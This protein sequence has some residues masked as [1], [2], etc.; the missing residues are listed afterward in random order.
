MLNSHTNE[1]RMVQ[2][3]TC[4]LPNNALERQLNVAYEIY[5]VTY[6]YLKTLRRFLIQISPPLEVF[7]SAVYRKADASTVNNFDQSYRLRP[8]KVVYEN[9]QGIVPFHIHTEGYTLDLPKFQCY[10]AK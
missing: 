9:S 5:R 10:A 8:K 7:K 1:L 6:L 4:T 2:K 3:V